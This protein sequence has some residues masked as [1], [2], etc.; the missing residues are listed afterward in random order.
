MKYFVGFIIAVF[1]GVASVLIYFYAQ[2]R[3]DA[4]KI[5]HYNPPLSTVIYDRNGKLLANLFE[6]E[7]RSYVDYEHIP[8][9]VIE[10]LV[11][12]ED[13]AFFDPRW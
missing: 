10:A 8:A 3:F 4:Y 12:M 9:R 11:A 6:K 5:V 2:V 1:V 7:H 13:T